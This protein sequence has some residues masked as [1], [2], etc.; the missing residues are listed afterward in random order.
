[1]SSVR[2]QRNRIYSLIVGSGD[3]FVEINNLQIKFDVTKTSS[4]KDKK[5]SA[6]IEIYNLSEDRRKKLE[7]DYVQVFF[8]CGYSDTGL[9]PLFSGQAV[10]VEMKKQG[11]S[12]TTRSSTDLITKIELDELYTAL[13]WK[14]VSKF[15][16]AGK[17]V[18]DVILTIIKDIPEISETRIGGERVK[19]QLPDGFPL[20]GTPR[21]NLDKISNEYGIEWQIDQG[22][23]IVSDIEGTYTDNVDSV[24]V[25]G[26]FTGLI[27]RPEYISGDSKK[28]KVGQTIDPKKKAKKQRKG[29]KFK[30]LLNPAIHAGDIIK[31]EFGDM[32]G[33]Y[34]VD[35][36]KHEG[37]FRS[38]TWYSTL[39]CSEKL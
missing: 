34:K 6:S 32:S 4:N 18:K 38:D 26:Q 25:I 8:S 27:D 21:Q 11:G 19:R 3:D 28:L 14:A 9:T 7:E 5:N 23:L 33:Y 13:N 1:M 35:E 12:L 2:Y 22:V 30:V 16:P 15:V 17:T 10:N 37:D 20:S 39:F 36:V 24:F 29:L 31:L